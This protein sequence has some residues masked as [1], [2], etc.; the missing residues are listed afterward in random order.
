MVVQKGTEVLR[1]VW[2]ADLAPLR[3]VSLVGYWDDSRSTS[4]QSVWPHPRHLIDD[5]DEGHRQRVVH[6]LQS[7]PVVETYFGFSTCRFGCA[8]S[9]GS[10]ERW[11]GK[12][13]WPQG[14]DH[15]VQHHAVG[16]PEAFLR[17]ME[18]SAY[19]VPAV[20]ST[21]RLLRDADIFLRWASKRAPTPVGPAGSLSRAEAR[22]RLREELGDPQPVSV[23]TVCGRWRIECGDYL[24]Y[25]LPPRSDEFDELVRTLRL[26]FGLPHRF[27]NGAIG[28]ELPLERR[29]DGLLFSRLDYVLPSGEDA[30]LALLVTANIAGMSGIMD[31]PMHARVAA[32]TEIEAVVTSG[33]PGVAL[34]HTPTR[35]TTGE[36][37]QIFQL[38]PMGEAWAT[39]LREMTIAIYV[40][41]DP[42]KWS[43]SI[44]IMVMRSA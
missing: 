12:F 3:R 9:R 2:D 7:G 19:V 32:W 15:Y 35:R 25:Q 39:V 18:E 14:L 27:A 17:H 5:W 16:L 28:I 13:L 33:A 1:A 8:G 31:L 20:D 42:L 34:R 4:E 29:E 41:T 22:A 21:V 40:P 11:D 43:A 37:A 26:R 24:S 10:G 38:V 6:Y 30:A 36:S 44:R 23:D